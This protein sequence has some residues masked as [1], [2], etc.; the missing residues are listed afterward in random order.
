MTSDE[1]TLALSSALRSVN[2]SHQLYDVLT[3]VATAQKAQGFA[4]TPGISMVIGCTYQNI[5]LH[6]LRNPSCFSF[7]DS[8]PPRKIMLSQEGIDLLMKVKTAVSHRAQPTATP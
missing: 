5:V 3:A 8:Q 4:T 2:L 6:L 7:D 1:Y